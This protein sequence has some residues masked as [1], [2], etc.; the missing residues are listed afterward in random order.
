MIMADFSIAYKITMSHEGGYVSH[1]A[2]R[3][4]MTFMG[5]SRKY[6]PTWNG[7]LII[8]RHK[9]SS[10]F[11]ENL[12]GN[13]ALEEQVFSF[14]KKNF[15][16]VNK[17]DQITNQSIANEVFD[18]GV[19]MGYKVAAECLQAAYN[20]LSK[21]ESAYKKIAVDG[22]IG[23]KTIAAINSHHYPLR[24]IKTLNILQGIRYVHICEKDSS[25]EVFFAGWIE[26]VAL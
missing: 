12:K 10:R 3:G 24:I 23:P 13:Q 14:Y 16:D 5:I 25:Q 15:W 1:P 9:L 21:N 11:P 8:D 17:L 26:R 7:W 6:H 20:L 18:T 4:Q 22:V 2:D 19:N